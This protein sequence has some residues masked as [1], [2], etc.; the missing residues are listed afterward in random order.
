MSRFLYDDQGSKVFACY[1]G[2]FWRVYVRFSFLSRVFFGVFPSGHED[3]VFL[4]WAV[5]SVVCGGAVGFAGVIFC[6][7]VSLV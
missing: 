6:L 1:G 3:I 2:D 4:V 5:F 7:V